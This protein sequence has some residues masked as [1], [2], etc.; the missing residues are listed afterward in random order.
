MGWS[1]ETVSRLIELYVKRDEIVLDRI[2]RIEQSKY[3]KTGCKTIGGN[4]C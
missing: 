2:R 4:S 3:C 1:E